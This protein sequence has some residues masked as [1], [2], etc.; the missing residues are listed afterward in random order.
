VLAIPPTNVSQLRSFLDAVTYYRTMWPRRSHVLAPLTEL[1]GRGR[2]EWTKDCQK[3]FDE[4]KAIIAAETLMIYPDHNKPF[5]VYTDASDYQMGAAILQ[6]GRP[7]AY[8]NRKHNNAQRNYTTMEKE[9][10]AVGM[11]LKEFRTM[12]MGAKL[13]VFADHKSLTF[14]TLN[15]Q[16]V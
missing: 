4:M 3:A 9:L 6:E 10:L 8:W 7:V 1:T 16:R 5:E 15:S 12:Q 2:W 13:T 14:R 11:C